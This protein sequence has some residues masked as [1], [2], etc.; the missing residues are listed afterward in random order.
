MILRRDFNALFN[1]RFTK[2]ANIHRVWSIRW[3]DQHEDYRTKHAFI[4]GKEGHYVLFS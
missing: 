2:L 3:E 4:K 1:F